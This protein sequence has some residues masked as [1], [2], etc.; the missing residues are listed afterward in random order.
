MI[1]VHNIRA[2]DV[3]EVTTSYVNNEFRIVYKRVY[4]QPKIILSKKA[5]GWVRVKLNPHKND[6]FEAGLNRCPITTKL[7]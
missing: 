3:F 2:G 1:K 6:Y 4:S 5:M 7:H